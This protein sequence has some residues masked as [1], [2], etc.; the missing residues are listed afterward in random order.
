MQHQKDLS[1]LQKV[2]GLNLCL[3]YALQF[4]LNFQC[5]SLLHLC[6]F[7]SSSIRYR[8]RL[9]IINMK[10]STKCS[11]FC[12]FWPCNPYIPLH[13]FENVLHACVLFLAQYYTKGWCCSCKLLLESNKHIYDQSR[14]CYHSGQKYSP[15]SVTFEV[16]RLR[17]SK[18]SWVRA[19]S[20]LY[21][22]GWL[23]PVTLMQ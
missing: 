16:G 20:S 10:E 21:R 17:P 3:T 6:S 15:S 13:F 12:G 2:K 23:I 18:K 19:V 14:H 4:I 9:I 5:Y 11:I 1:L 22:T 8:T 7:C